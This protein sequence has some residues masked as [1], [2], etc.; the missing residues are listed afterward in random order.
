MPAISRALLVI[1]V[2][3]LIFIFYDGLAEMVRRWSSSEEYGYGY[4]IPAISIFLIWQKSDLLQGM[5][6][7]G[8]WTG[9]AV[10]LAGVALCVLGVMSSLYVIIQY[11]FVIALTGVA[12]T[13]VGWRGIRLLRAPLLFL[14]FMIPL[15]AF[16]YNNLSSQLQLVSSEIGVALIR[17]FN[18]SVHLEGNIIDLGAYRLQV[19]DA[20]SG[21]RYLFPLVSLSFVAAY[22]YRA[23]FWKRGILFLSSIPITILM[24]SIRVGVIGVLV[25]YW[26]SEQAEGLLH[27]FE[28]WVIFVTCIGILVGEMW[29]LARFGKEQRPFRE[30]FGL[31]LPELPPEDA[32]RHY[33]HVPVQFMTTVAVLLAASVAV[34]SVGE[35]AE[36]I[37]PR[38]DFTNFPTKVGEW[39]GKQDHLEQIYLDTLKVDDYLIA[40]YADT[41]GDAINLYVAYYSSQRAGQTVH[42]PRSCIPGGGWRIDSLTKHDIDIEHGN[43]GVL[44]ASRALVSKGDVTQLVY[45]WFQQRGRVIANEYLLKWYLFWDSLTRRRTDGALVRITALI[46]P[47]KD[48]SAADRELGEFATKVVPL[49]GDYVPN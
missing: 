2:S 28:G 18:I 41:T 48:I 3:L 49:L 17:L 47:G 27:Y 19:V 21:L 30:V 25:E 12:L 1:A 24:N 11:S 4:L 44:A 37:P 5:Q 35:R 32:T 9:L 13:L 45:Y 40:D 42:S 7:S 39:E 34:T 14:V 23:A 10:V 16:I 36:V 26:G 29:I 15:P 46:G 20:C 31:E 22:I 33:R 6:F 38:R 8:T 43:A